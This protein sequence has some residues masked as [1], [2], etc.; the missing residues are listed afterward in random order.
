MKIAC[1]G[2]GSLIWDPRN[3]PVE[4]EWF[5]NGPKLRIEFARQSKDGRLTLVIEPSSP[6]VPCLWAVM[7]V[8]SVADAH[9][10]LVEREGTS[11]KYIATW[12]LGEEAPKS[13]PS[14]PDWAAAHDIK[15]VV[16]TA[17]P[18][19]FNDVEITPT[20][21]EAIKYLD[22][23]TGETRSKAQEYITRAPRQ[24]D[25]PY[26]RQIAVELRWQSKS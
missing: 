1:L 2:W 11:R 18:P 22:S 6:E 8:N 15:G 17:L 3:L 10:A 4:R 9:R 25:T 13:I 16:W 21:S 20:Q 14:L 5:E 7:T 12:S 19:K 24:I 26:R 23:L